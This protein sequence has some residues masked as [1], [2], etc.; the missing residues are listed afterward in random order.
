MDPSTKVKYE[1]RFK[2]IDTVGLF[3]TKITNE[4]IINE[5]KVYLKSQVPKVYI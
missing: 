5:I 1:Y 3:D 2:L 4:K